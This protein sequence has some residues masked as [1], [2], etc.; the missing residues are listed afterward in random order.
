LVDMLANIFHALRLFTPE[1]PNL[2]LNYVTHTYLAP[3]SKHHSSLYYTFRATLSLN[4][5]HL[6]ISGALHLRG[7]ATDCFWLLWS[8][9]RR[10]RL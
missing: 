5:V 1:S 3:Y 9:T 6:F 2:R 7:M 10:T 8:T 4:A